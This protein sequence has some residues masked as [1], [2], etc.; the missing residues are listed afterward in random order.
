[1]ELHVPIVPPNMHHHNATECVMKSFNA[2]FITILTGIDQAFPANCWDLLLPQAELTVTCFADR[3]PSWP[4]PP[5]NTL[6]DPS[7]LTPLSGISRL[8]GAHPCKA[9]NKGLA[10]TMVST[11]SQHCTTTAVT[12]QFF[13]V[14]AHNMKIV[15]LTPW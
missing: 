2:H 14:Y 15:R 9:C 5:G 8:L 6:L 7:A 12:L 13:A 3:G 4:S 1:M 10:E 11:S